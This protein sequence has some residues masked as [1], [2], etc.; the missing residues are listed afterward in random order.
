MHQ[1]SREL[2]GDVQCGYAQGHHRCGNGGSSDIQANDVEGRIDGEI[3]TVSCEDDAID[4]E[5]SPL[6]AAGTR[7]Q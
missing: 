2:W 4:E 6:V 1:E 7:Q 3:G 5:E